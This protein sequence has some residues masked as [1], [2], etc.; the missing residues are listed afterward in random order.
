MRRVFVGL[1][2]VFVGLAAQLRN[3]RLLRKMRNLQQGEVADKQTRANNGHAPSP[4]SHGQGQ[5]RVYGVEE[6]L[7]P[8]D[9]DALQVEVSRK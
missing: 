7:D 6:R 8:E 1:A 9:G 4:P 5:A 3:N 2:Q